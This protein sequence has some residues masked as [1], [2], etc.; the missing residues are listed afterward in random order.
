MRRIAQLFGGAAALALVVALWPLHSRPRVLLVGD[1]ITAQYAPDAIPELRRRGYEPVVRAYPGAG[2]LDRGPRLDLLRQVR[3]DIHS[4]R[5]VFVVAEFSGNYGI[6][7]PPLPG[8]ALG[9]PQFYAEWARAVDVVTTNATRSGAT[10]VWLVPPRSIR[11]DPTGDNAL[12]IVYQNEAHHRRVGI[13]DARP[14]VASHEF[15]GDLHAPDGRHLSPAGAA[16]VA[17]AVA[18]RV[19]A[20]SAWSMRLRQLANSVALRTGLALALLSLLLA[21]A[22]RRGPPPGRTSARSMRAR[23]T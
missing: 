23:T 18:Q 11:G 13:V 6:V 17:R 22:A 5:P 21:I 16:L 8:V 7:D 15:A 9:T 12:A 20:T 2:I 10:V 4:V 1:S 19:S 14:L 3:S